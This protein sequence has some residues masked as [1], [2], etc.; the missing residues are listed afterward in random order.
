MS[1]QKP[2]PFDRGPLTSC[3]QTDGQFRSR[4]ITIRPGRRRNSEHHRHAGGEPPDGAGVP[5]CL[6]PDT[7]RR[8]L[9]GLAGARAAGTRPALR[10][11]PAVRPAGRAR[12]DGL[13]LVRAKC[14]DNDITDEPARAFRDDTGKVQ[15]MNT[16]QVNYRWI[17]SST[18]DSTYT[19]PCTKTMSSQQQL[20]RV[21]LQPQGMAGLAVDARREDDLRA[22]P[23]GVPGAGSCVSGCPSNFACWYNSLTSAVSTNSGA[24]F[25]QPTAPAQLVASIPYQ[26]S[27]DGPNGY[28][29]PSNIVRAG[30][31]YFY[32]I[33]R[34]EDKGLQQMGSCLMRTWDLSDP[35][36]VAG[37]ER[38]RL[39]RPVRQ[40]LHVHARPGSARLRAGRLQ[41]HR[42]D[43]REPH[44]QHVL[45][46]VDAGR[47][48][49]RRPRGRQAAGRLLRA[50]GRP[51]RT[52]PTRP[53]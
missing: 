17:A 45:Q 46:E 39:R 23:H 7:G 9:P 44:L 28:F 12:G 31:G 30:D 16:H 15:L 25:T 40:S 42:H 33:F 19:H 51:A 43:Q 2:W 48:L 32:T 36:V 34:A 5:P 50:V 8:A 14:E 22:R 29:T 26:F 53:S 6:V 52:G 38:L 1:T 10:L 41:Q 21:Q 13:R 49:R 37:V 47:Q 3:A 18:L 11:Q 27:M 20:H 35:D 4:R 24:T